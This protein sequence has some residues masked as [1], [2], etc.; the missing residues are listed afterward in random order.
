MDSDGDGIN[1]Q[2]EANADADNDGQPNFLDTDSD[3]DGINDAVEGTVD[4]DEDLTPNY[5]DTDSDADGIADKVETATDA[6]ADGVANYLDSDSDDDGLSDTQEYSD[7]FSKDA[8]NDGNMNF[9]DADSD[10]DGLL[11]SEETVV[12]YDADGLPSFVDIDSDN[13]LIPDALETL[14]DVDADGLGNAYDKDSDGD[15][16][17]D[18][19]E[20]QITVADRNEAGVIVGLEL[21]DTDQDGIA[22]L[23]DTDS[24]ND[25]ILD[26]FET[27]TTLDTDAT[28]VAADVNGNGILDRFDV[29][30]TLGEDANADG[31]DDAITLLDTDA[32]GIADVLDLDS[33]NDGLLDIEEFVPLIDA[34]RSPSQVDNNSDGIADPA[35]ELTSQIP[36]DS[37]FDGVPDFKDLDSDGDGI[38]DIDATIFKNFDGTIEGEAKDGMIDLSAQSLAVES[39][40]D[41]GDGI[42]GFADK[43]PSVRGSNDD[44]DGDGI[45]SGTDLD[46]DNDG[47]SDVKEGNADTDG[48]GIVDRLDPDSDGDGIPD[49]LEANLAPKTGDDHDADGVDNAYDVDF[50]AGENDIDNDGVVDVES[51]KLEFTQSTDSD[52]DGILDNKELLKQPPLNQ[53]QNFNGIDDRYDVSVTG[54]KDA[55]ADGFDDALFYVADIDKDGVINSQDTDSDNDGYLDRIE[56]KDYNEDGQIDF[57]QVDSGV[58]TQIRGFGSLSVASLLM[59]LAAVLLLQVKQ[60]KKWLLLVSLLPISFSGFSAEEKKPSQFAPTLKIAKPRIVC[61][62]RSVPAPPFCN[63]MKKPVFGKHKVMCQRPGKWGL[64]GIL[65]LNFSLNYS[66]TI[67]HRLSLPVSMKISL[68][69]VVYLI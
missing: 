59:L 44:P 36:A 34:Q 51:A 47:I 64:A 19:A 24:D 22:N 2:V 27:E 49:Y 60:R 8:D 12:D 38:F 33:D 41:D 45:P 5:L 21:L 66:L 16:I 50:L 37:D 26:Q 69:P 17:P 20:Q 43:E 52:G 42:V 9:V 63:Q 13:D 46:D 28:L 31:I 54:G 68:A 1:D 3:D 48:D 32:D 25:G 18:V 10:N 23:Y 6:D 55:N 61:M 30:I 7:S 4:T 53:D 56:A 39:V 57:L 29:S 35:S 40:D 58:N 67:L 62:S 11:D 14:D 65:N 15:W